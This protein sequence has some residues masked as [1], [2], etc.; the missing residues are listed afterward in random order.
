MDKNIFFCV[1]VACFIQAEKKGIYRYNP[2]SIYMYHRGTVYVLKLKG[3]MRML[4]RLLSKVW[5]GLSPA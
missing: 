5:L 2:I 1:F 4:C 3:I